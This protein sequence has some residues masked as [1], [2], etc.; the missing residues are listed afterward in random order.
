[1]RAFG[2]FQHAILGGLIMS[3]FLTL[4]LMLERNPVRRAFG[5][6]AAL[7]GFFTLSSAAIASL[8]LQAALHLYRWGMKLAG[9]RHNWWA[10]FWAAVVCIVTLE[11]VSQSGA[12]SAI[13]R[14][15][16]LNPATGSYRLLIWDYGTANVAS[17][18]LFGIGYDEY[19]RADWM[20]RSVD[21][22]WLLVAIRHG[23]PALV[24]LLA[25][26]LALIVRL[27]II[28]NRLPSV[29]GVPYAAFMIALFSF[30]AMGITVAYWT[31]A[32]AFFY[33]LVGCSAA[34]VELY[35]KRVALA[36]QRRKDGG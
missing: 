9:Y 32:L 5:I 28:S 2:P 4:Y 18:P 10:L 29:A 23:L 34:L 30:T 20:G 16:A 12:V 8:M 13:I 35:D 24:P 19:A 22:H 21:N 15:A 14:Y 25:M 17:N 31:A 27:A 6:G 36:R 33:F 26:P 11:L 1:L 3:S 7:A